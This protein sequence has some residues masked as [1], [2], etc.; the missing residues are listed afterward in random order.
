MDRQLNP[1]GRALA[2][3]FSNLILHG[4]APATPPGAAYLASGRAVIP[5]TIRPMEVLLLG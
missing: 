2:V 5:V 3:L 1:P 4:A